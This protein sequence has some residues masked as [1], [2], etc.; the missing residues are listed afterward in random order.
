MKKLLTAAIL[1]ATC[2]ALCAAVWSRNGEAETISSDTVM[3]ATAPTETPE[4]Q[5]VCL[6]QNSELTETAEEEKAPAIL[7]SAT[8]VYIPEET[9]MPEAEPAVTA[10]EPSATVQVIASQTT[11]SSGT[12]P[13]HTD[14]YPENVYSEEFIYDTDGNLIG[15]T[16]TYPTAFDSDTVWIDGKAY[17]NVPGFGLVEWGGPSSVTEDYIMYESGNKVGIMGG[18]EDASATQPPTD[19]L[20]PTGEVIDQTIGEAP[21]RSSTSPNYKPDNTPPNDPNARIIP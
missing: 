6:A 4:P 13:Y 11:P 21:E 19:W 7:A 12:D 10:A 5:T 20:E 17:G 18:E 14:I 2:A 1:L 8:P 15:K 3:S 9:P 16:T